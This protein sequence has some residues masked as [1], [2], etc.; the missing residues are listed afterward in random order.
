MRHHLESASSTRKTPGARPRIAV[1]SPWAPQPTG[2]ADYARRLIESLQAHYLIDV[3]HD[4]AIE[5]ELGPCGC[6]FAAVPMRL[7]RRRA[8]ALGYH[9]ILYQMGNSHYH[10]FLYDSLVTVPGIVTLH[11]FDIAGFHWGRAFRSGVGDPLARFAAEFALSHPE[12]AGDV[13][14]NLEAWSRLPGG[15]PRAW[16]A[17]SRP[18]NRRVLDRAAAVVV[19][20]PWCLR[21]IEQGPDARYQGKLRVVPHGADPASST[22]EQR[23]ATRLQFDLPRA[24]FILGCFGLITPEKLNA[25]V[26]R[27]FAELADRHP[28]M[29]LVLVGDESDNGDARR[30]ASASGIGA[31]V[32]FLGRRS[33]AEYEALVAV[34]D[35]GIALRRPPTH[36]E[37]SGSLLHLLRFGVPTIINHVDTFAD[38]PATV[39]KAIRWE[40]DGRAC[41]VA[42]IEELARDHD[43]RR[44]LGAEA[45]RFIA[46]FHNWPR[47]A[48][49]YADLI[50]NPQP[51][52]PGGPLDAGIPQG[53]EMAAPA[54]LER[55]R[56]AA[57]TAGALAPAAGFPGRAT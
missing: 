6:R 1:V 46:R 11:D 49:A 40:A 9:A 38:F 37:T 18:M 57:F 43:Q 45:G 15:A 22:P 44:R 52:S 25:E 16:G 7:F 8:D 36:G 53:P 30:A 2:V 24:A 56:S 4:D 31:R 32:R 54:A 42:A 17:G 48:A 50:A 14:P 13:L 28:E 19:H 10:E 39:A 20:S 5:P 21:K 41:L 29:I 12:A 26:I 27:A 34:T 33:D 55:D 47:V 51:N 3:V 23:A 35:L